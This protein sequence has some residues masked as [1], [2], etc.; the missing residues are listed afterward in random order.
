MRTGTVPIGFTTPLININL[1]ANKEISTYVEEGK[2]THSTKSILKY[3]TRVK[4]FISRHQRNVNKNSG[5]K[6]KD[7]NESRK[8]RI[9]TFIDGTMAM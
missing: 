8:A 7:N 1:S 4:E 5:S 2:P 3:G 6:Q 9:H